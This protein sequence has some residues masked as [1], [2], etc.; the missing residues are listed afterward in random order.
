MCAR[1][2]KHERLKFAPEFTQD[3]VFENESHSL[4][5]ECVF[6]LFTENYIVQQKHHE[7][8]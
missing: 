4:S 8:G 3:L 5:L 2:T 1:K 7:E 6:D